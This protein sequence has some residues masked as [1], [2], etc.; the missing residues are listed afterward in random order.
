MTIPLPLAP[1][2]YPDVLHVR[3]EFLPV[4]F[5]DK[6]IICDIIL[7]KKKLITNSPKNIFNIEKKAS[8]L[9]YYIYFIMCNFYQIINLLNR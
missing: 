4:P 9:I 3:R 6:R 8:V 2:A 1:H 7:I 5:I